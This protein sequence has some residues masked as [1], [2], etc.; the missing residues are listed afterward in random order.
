MVR[1]WQLDVLSQAHDHVEIVKLRL[2]NCV[3]AVVDKVAT[4]ENRKGKN[5]HVVVLVF[6]GITEPLS[7]DD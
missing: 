1:L 6:V 5:S 7:V 3:L 2:I 4:H